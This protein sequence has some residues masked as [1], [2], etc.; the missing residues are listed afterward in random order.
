MIVTVLLVWM[1][2]F[3]RA[4]CVGFVILCS[5]WPLSRSLLVLLGSALKLSLRS[6]EEQLII[7]KDLCQGIM[8]WEI[9]FVLLKL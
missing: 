4:V 5:V 1:R 2:N 6:L 7:W 9:V 8:G 3:I